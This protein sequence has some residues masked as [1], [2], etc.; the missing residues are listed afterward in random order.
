[1]LF[2][3]FYSFPPNHGKDISFISTAQELKFN[4]LNTL[5][6]FCFKMIST[7]IRLEWF[8]SVEPVKAF[9]ERLKLR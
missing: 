3:A 4:I 7:M 2:I 5:N 8:L 9:G 1:M 6:C